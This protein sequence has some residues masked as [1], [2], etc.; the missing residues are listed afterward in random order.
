MQSLRRA[1]H[2]LLARDQHLPSH[3]GATGTPGGPT[4]AHHKKMSQCLHRGRTAGPG[5]KGLPASLSHLFP[6][7]QLPREP[8]NR[9]LIEKESEMKTVKLATMSLSPGGAGN[10][11]RL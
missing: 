6:L 7:L 8:E 11:E 10:R 1:G 4:N 5:K 2:K 9:L 3:G